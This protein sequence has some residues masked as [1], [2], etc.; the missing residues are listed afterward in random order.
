MRFYPAR[1]HSHDGRTVCGDDV[2]GGN[3]EGA[4]VK[5]EFPGNGA[6]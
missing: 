5:G 6:G 3:R 4:V 2:A 1:N